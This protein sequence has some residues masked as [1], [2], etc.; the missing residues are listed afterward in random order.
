MINTFIVCD[1]IK[2]NNQAVFVYCH[3]WSKNQITS[4]IWPMQ[5]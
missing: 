3:D 5:N 1:K 4:F 2:Q